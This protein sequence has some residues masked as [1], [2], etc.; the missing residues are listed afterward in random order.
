MTSCLPHQDL[1]QPLFARLRRH[2]LL[3]DGACEA[4]AGA[5]RGPRQFARGEFICSEGDRVDAL[6][7]LVDGLA[8]GSRR[9]PGGGQQ[10]VALQAPGDL[11]DQHGFVLGRVSLTIQAIVDCTVQTFPRSA[12]RLTL[13]ER[14]DVLALMHGEMAASALLAQERMLSLGRRTARARLAHLMCEVA[15]RGIGEEGG[16]VYA[17]PMTQNDLADLLGL[18]VVHTNRSLQELRR[19]SLLEFSR[20]RLRI[21]DA[22]GLKRVAAFDPSYLTLSAS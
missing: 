17:L 2:G 15:E 14:P 20:G 3:D 5:A 22:P 7:V 8:L 12:L 13:A 18:S 16:Q 21:L 19:E 4:L 1:L 9:L 11:L 10:H 6:P